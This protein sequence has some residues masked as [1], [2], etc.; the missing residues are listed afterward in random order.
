[1]VRVEAGLAAVTSH[2]DRGHVGAAALAQAQHRA[3]AA[4]REDEVVRVARRAPAAAAV[5]N[6]AEDAVGE[7]VREVELARV[8]DVA[9]DVHLDRDVDGPTGVPARVDAAEAGEA[10]RVGSLDPAHERAVAGARAEA[11]VDPARVRVPDVDR[12]TLDRLARRRV[13]DPEPEQ[14]RDAR[15]ALGDVA[16]ELLAGD[17]VRAFGL[18]G[19]EDTGHRARGNRGRAG[20]V[21]LGDLPAR[22]TQERTEPAAEPDQRASPRELRLEHAPTVPR[23]RESGLRLLANTP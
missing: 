21:R 16:P 22:H 15:P 13:D 20:A 18:L 9:D 19:R 10:A 23:E 5:R 1:M 7:L 11:R 6:A 2:C 14:Q 3:P 12:R 8:D 17:V 4:V